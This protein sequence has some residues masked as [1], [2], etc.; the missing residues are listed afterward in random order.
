MR[1]LRA[2]HMVYYQDQVSRIGEG[3][4]GWLALAEVE[5][6]QF[7]YAQHWENKQIEHG[8]EHSTSNSSTV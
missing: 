8:V 6:L 1:G 4:V 5:R 3:A 7:E 2:T